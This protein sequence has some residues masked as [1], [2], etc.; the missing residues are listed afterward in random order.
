MGLQRYLTHPDEIAS[1]GAFTSFCDPDELTGH[2][3][4]LARRK[5]IRS[6]CGGSPFPRKAMLEIMP[7]GKGQAHW[8]EEAI[9]LSLSEWEEVSRRFP[10]K[11]LNIL[12]LD[13]DE[14]YESFSTQEANAVSQQLAL[15]GLSPSHLGDILRKGGD[16]VVLVDK[17]M[18]SEVASALARNGLD[19]REA[20]SFHP[21]ACAEAVR[22]G[23]GSP[24]LDSVI[25]RAYHIGRAEAK[26]A[27]VRGFVAVNM[28]LARDASQPVAAG[29]VLHH[30]LKGAVR[31]DE[32]NTSRKQGRYNLT[33]SIAGGVRL[34][35]RG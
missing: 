1:T 34:Q 16:V 29:D 2:W 10:L 3:D 4:E 15:G 30:L 25:S 6:L 32:L 23:V 24:R 11:W 35:M 33:C 27:V 31:I 5:I 13:T 7:P 12:K 28:R 8:D 19:C 22:L 20:K 14:S 26:K 17:R 18:E 21:E 9:R